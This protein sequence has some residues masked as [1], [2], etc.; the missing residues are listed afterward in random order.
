MHYPILFLLNHIVDKINLVKYSF[1]VQIVKTTIV[2][3]IC[4]C[5]ATIMK[6]IPGLKQIV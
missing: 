1:D 6:R 3:S 5:L 4:M 2:L